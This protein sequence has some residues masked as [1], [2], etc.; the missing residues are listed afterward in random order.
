MEYLFAF[1]LCFAL[2]YFIVDL[3]IDRN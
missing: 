3:L 2:G 1:V